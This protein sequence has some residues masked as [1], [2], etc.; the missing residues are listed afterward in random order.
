[1]IEPSRWWLRIEAAFQS[2]D[3]EPRCLALSTGGSNEIQKNSV[4]KLVTRA[5]RRFVAYAASTLPPSLLTQC[6][7]QA[8]VIIR[9]TGNGNRA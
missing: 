4:A 5:V 2:V 1:M 3:P 8:V 6:C 7:Q 9:A